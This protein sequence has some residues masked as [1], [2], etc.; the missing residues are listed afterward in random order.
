MKNCQVETT[1]RRVFIQRSAGVGAVTTLSG[2][3][4]GQAAAAEPSGKKTKVG[5]I[6]CGS[7]SRKYLPHLK[8]CPFVELVSTCDIIPER[9]KRAAERFNVPNHYPHIDKMLD[10]ATF[11]LLVDLTDMQE[12]Y[13][14]NKQALEAGKHVWSEKPMANDLA[15]GQELLDL[16]KKKGVR[17]WGAPTVVMS[18]QFRFMAKTLREGKLGRVAAA[19]ASYGN[20]GPSWASFFYDKNG[21][22]MPDLGVYKLD[23]TYRTIRTCPFHRGHVEHRHPDTGY[24]GKRENQSRGRGQRHGS[25][26]P[27]R[28]CHF[29]HAV[30]VQLP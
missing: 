3:P 2:L 27:W 22:S 17:I 9:S 15:G 5:V 1:N 24:Q 13:R 11:D 18:P 26:G 7:V 8:S 21:G 4:T 10:G 30:W 20:A 14:L 19:H 29:A 28:W 12:H 25:N 6:G 16:A 23:D